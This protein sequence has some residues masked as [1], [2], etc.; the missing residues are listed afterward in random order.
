MGIIEK[1]ATKSAIFS[2]L[3]AALGFVTVMWMSHILSPAEN[4][5]IRLIVSYSALFAQFA[6]LGFT[7]VTS[8]FFPFFRNQ[9]KGHHGFLFYALIVTFIGFLVCWGIFYFIQPSIIE[10]NKIKS[11]LFTTYLVYLIPLTFCVVYFNIFDSYLRACYSSVAGTFTKEFLQRV[12]ILLVL[13]LY[14]LNIISIGAFVF[15]YFLATALPSVLLLYYIIQQK[16]WH[17]KPARGFISKE[18][19][20]EMIKLGIYTLLAGGAGAIILN[21]DIIM[22]NQ[23]LDEKQTGIYGIAFYF[24]SII[25]IPARSIYRITSGIVAENFKQKKIQEI[26][27]LYQQSCNTQLTI[28][29][30]LFIGIW[31]NIDNIMHLLPTAYAN[32]KSVIL[33][34]T[35]GYLVEM[36]TGINQVIIANSDHYKYDT[37]I[38]FILVFVT[39]IA[40]YLLIPN[41]GIIGSASATAISV[42]IGNGLRFFLLFNKYKMQPFNSNT[43]KIIGIAAI[44][45]IPGLLIPYLNNWVLDT[46]IRSGA[47]GGLFIVLLL[48]L[49]AAPELNN[50]IRKNLKHVPMLD[51]ILS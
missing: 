16:E 1:Q 20:Q 46:A 6:N 51:K 30:L 48:K 41:F 5:S 24:G 34:L 8:R 21:I 4:G 19:R 39:I 28:G 35:L 13:F 44:A 10:S 45:I 26:H 9:D 42:I 2:Y 32:G 40:N 43:I 22:V 15:L 17:I 47:V 29:I 25:L 11:P 12:I 27:K 36:G 23:L 50:K 37:F 38:V 7:S 33:I 3:G 18:L 14:F 49:E 31:C